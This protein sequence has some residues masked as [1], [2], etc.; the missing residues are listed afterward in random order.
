MAVIPF[1]MTGQSGINKDIPA[2][3][4]PPPDWSDGRN[5]RFVNGKAVRVDGSQQVFGTPT[6]VPYWLMFAYGAS[7]A[8]WMYS[9]LVKVYATDGATHT[10]ITRASGGDYAATEERL[11]NGGILSG[12]PVITNGVDKPQFWSPVG[13]G[14]DLADLSNWPTNDRAQVIKPF[15]NFLVAGNIIRSSVQFPHMVM[16][17]HPAAPGALPSSWDVADPTMLAGERDLGDA[18]PGGI[19]DMLQLRDILVIY[20]DNTTWGMQF[21]GGQEVMR[22]YMILSH[23]GILGPH[24]VKEVHEGRAHILGLP[25]DM[26]V[27]DGQTTTSVVDKRMKR[28]ITKTL[29]DNQSSARK[30]FMFVHDNQNE[31]WFCI[32]E[33][34]HDWP[35]L[36]IV[37]NFRENTLGIRELVTG[38]SL[39]QSGVVSDTSAVWNSDSQFWDLDASV[40]DEVTFRAAFFTPVGSVPTATKIIEYDVSQQ[41]DGVDYTSYIERTDIALVG[42]DRLTGM[43]KADLEARKLCKRVWP[44]MKFDSAPI[45]IKIGTQDKIGGPVT[46]SAS[47]SFNPATQSYLDFSQAGL[48]IAIW[49]GSTVQG[50]F[51]AEGFDMEIEIIGRM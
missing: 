37:W 40:W 7:N 15:K 8:F 19:I 2:Q 48:L 28:F 10:D 22:T 47:Q 11:W 49:M 1:H 30:S 20:K 18:F 27:F 17:S 13:L 33:A 16:W 12:I 46:W 5:I 32:P 51:E 41:H 9:N 38:T 42:K 36:A 31:A 50:V 6:V 44:K 23:S 39:I 25:D 45:D 29:E 4:L 35:N 43:F 26:I 3:E 24:C 34:G 14:T 21:I